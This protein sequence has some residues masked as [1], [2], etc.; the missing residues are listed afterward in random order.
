VRTLPIAKKKIR[1]SGSAVGPPKKD[2]VRDRKTD[3]ME[4]LLTKQELKNLYRRLKD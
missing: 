2:V 4:N 3:L 1:L